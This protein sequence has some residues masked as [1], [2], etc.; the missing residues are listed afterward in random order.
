MTEGSSIWIEL[1]WPIATVI[2][3][4]IAV[5]GAFLTWKSAQKTLRHKQYETASAQ[6]RSVST[7][8]HW[9]YVTRTAAIATLAK[10]AKDYPKDYDEPVMRAFE[11]FLSFPPRYGTNAVKEGQVDYTSRDTVAIVDAINDRPKGWCRWGTWVKAY[12]IK[13]PPRRPFRVT[14][15]GGVERNPNYYD[16]GRRKMS[17]VSKND[18]DGREWSVKLFGN[19]AEPMQIVVAITPDQARALINYENRRLQEVALK[20]DGT[21]PREVDNVG[22][23]IM[24]I[25]QTA[26][27]AG[28]S[29]S[30]DTS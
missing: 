18:E 15:H 25:L 2:S 22:E 5:G 14:D 13:L 7:A 24:S 26:V 3:A 1:A 27:I 23:A 10:L 20:S 6:L 9:N 11:A 29:N 19:E 17:A 4:G 28:D 16:P 12:A 8:G 30:T 21:D